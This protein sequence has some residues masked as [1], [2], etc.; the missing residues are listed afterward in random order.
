MVFRSSLAAKNHDY[1][2]VQYTATVKPGEKTDFVYE[3]VRR[4][5][6]NAKQNR[7]TIDT[8]TK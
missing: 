2:T 5:G 6:R 1:Q 4:Q 7:V 8:T 3:V